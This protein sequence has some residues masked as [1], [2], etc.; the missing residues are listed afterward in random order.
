MF[1]SCDIE[2]DQIKQLHVK[3][4]QLT[5]TDL[6]DEESSGSLLCTTHTY[7]TE[8]LIPLLVSVS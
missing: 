4:G 2:I 1:V 7:N 8:R 6:S 5:L 3:T